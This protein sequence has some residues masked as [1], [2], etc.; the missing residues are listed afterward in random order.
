MTRKIILTKTTHELILSYSHIK[1]NELLNEGWDIQS[2]HINS[3]DI[4]IW[5]MI[6]STSMLNNV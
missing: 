3:K 6:K 2:T 1:T 4:I 5:V